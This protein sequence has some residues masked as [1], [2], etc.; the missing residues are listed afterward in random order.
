MSNNT[1]QE[2]LF[3]ATGIVKNFGGVQ[4]L[5]GVDFDV[6]PGEIH[7]LLGQNGAGKSTLVKILNGVHAAGST[8]APSASTASPSFCLAR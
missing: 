4:A 2:P 7:A 3:S 8:S 6:V 5:R 1:A